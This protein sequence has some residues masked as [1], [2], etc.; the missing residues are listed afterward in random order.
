MGKLLIILLVYLS[1]LLQSSFLPHFY[2]INLVIVIVVFF[3]LYEFEKNSFGI[4]LAFLGGLFLDFLSS[5]FF[6]FYTILLVLI[7]LFIK[8]IIK[9]NVSIPIFERK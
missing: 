1:A 6:G 3:N 4:Y 7:S 8:F 2:Y 9:R 5:Y